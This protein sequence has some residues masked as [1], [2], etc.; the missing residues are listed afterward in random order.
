MKNSLLNLAKN[1]IINIAH[2]W[3]I[4]GITV[5]CKIFG[6]LVKDWNGKWTVW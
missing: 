5:V 6:K 3:D 4:W 2:T 1:C